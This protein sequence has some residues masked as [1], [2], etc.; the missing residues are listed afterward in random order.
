[1]ELQLIPSGPLRLFVKLLWF[2][3]GGAPEASRRELVL[4]TGSMHLAIR[5]EDHPLHVYDSVDAVTSRG[6]SSAVVGGARAGF[7]VRDISRPVPSL[8]AMLH[9]GAS[10]ALLGVPADELGGRHTPLEE[11]WHDVDSIRDRLRGLASPQ[12][13]LA[14]FATI[15]EARLPRVRGLHP[16]VAHALQR[17]DAGCEVRSVVDEVGYSHHQ[18][19]TVFR[20]AVGLPPKR[21]CRVLRFHRVLERLAVDTDVAWGQLALDA[22]YSDQAHFTREFHAFSGVTPGAFRRIAP[23]HAHHVPLQFPSRRR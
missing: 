12:E 11:L 23:R 16:A 19:I 18:F 20:E 7:Y 2:S 6:I 5:L 1:M 3:D 22:G 14:T 8:G 17:F 4:P 15:L 13:Q 21:Y 10:L 9:P